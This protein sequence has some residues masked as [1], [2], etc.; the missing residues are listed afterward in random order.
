MK[1]LVRKKKKEKRKKTIV[2]GKDAKSRLREVQ[3]TAAS[4]N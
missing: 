4:G 3:T 1:G 2:L